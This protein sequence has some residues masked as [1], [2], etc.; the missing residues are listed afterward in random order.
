M[1]T[2]LSTLERYGA[3]IAHGVADEHVNIV[4]YVV[5]PFSHP[6]A[7]VDI[8]AGFV[9][10]RRAYEA[11]IAAL[12][13]KP[14][15]LTLQIIPAAFIASKLGPVLRI[16]VFHRLA[17]EVY[18]RAVPTE[19][20]SFAEARQRFSPAIHL[21]RPRPRVLEFCSTPTPS[22]ALLRENEILH[23]A[24]TQSL[25]ERWVSVAWN[26]ASGG[27]QKTALINLARRNSSFLRPFTDVCAEIW[28]TTV[29]IISR[30]AIRWRIAITKL[31]GD[32]LDD[33]KETWSQFATDH[34]RIAA[35][36]LL[37]ASLDAGIDIEGGNSTGTASS[38]LDMSGFNPTVSLYTTP[39]VISTPT[40]GNT[41]SPDA[42]GNNVANT[43][44]GGGGEAVDLDPDAV[45][46]D[47]RDECW[48]LLL[49]HAPISG[50][51]GIETDR[52]LGAGLLVCKE[53]ESGWA[54]AVRLTVLGGRGF[55]DVGEVV[56]EI[57]VAW[58][59]L[60]VIGGFY[61]GEGGVGRGV[62]WHLARVRDALKVARV[63]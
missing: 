1:K 47:G 35:V 26:D 28:D 3:N 52:A 43:P 4:I 40:P 45:L 48:G 36:F 17:V 32:M 6:S 56:K 2:V 29:D 57:L 24:Y 18:S 38:V 14:N 54:V 30:P 8:S 61:R 13:V 53:G 46:V 41:V 59:G 49:K 31:G 10:M 16:N 5:N 7:L 20:T 12:N 34:P 23:L 62:P 51:L 27:T 37:S 60:A 42:F 21:S 25:D 9:R 15:H 44:G 50:E 58:R 11:A 19:G 39:P 63:M 55:R 22:P 33:E